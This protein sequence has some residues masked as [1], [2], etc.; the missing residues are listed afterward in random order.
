MGSSTHG[1]LGLMLLVI[2]MLM[3]QATAHTF[4]VGGKHGWVPKPKERY[5]KWAER[6]RFQVNDT[7][8]FKFHEKH[9]SVLVVD[10][11]SYLKCKTKH[12]IHKLGGH[13]HS[14]FKLD[15]SGPFYFISGRSKHCRRGQK[16]IVVVLALS[17]HKH[18]SHPPHH[19][20]HHAPSHVPSHAP[21]HA[22][23]H[24]PHHAHHHAPHHAPSH[25]PHHHAP[26]HHGPHHHAPHHAP[27]HHAPSHAPH[28]HAP[29]HAPHHHPPSHVPANAPS[30]V[31]RHAPASG[32]AHAH[33]WSPVH[34]PAP[35]PSSAASSRFG[36]SVSVA[37]GLGIWVVLVLSS[38]I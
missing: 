35:G 9:D 2:T 1:F 14:E 4:Y 24:A 20:P 18:P 5:N 37:M 8:H 34:A 29:S 10:K 13:G 31:P 36:G 12:P 7:L 16:L 19:A 11:E 38:F 25:A 26:H 32:P 33:S 22:P 30:S 6:T 15:R 28:H 17:H 27:H 21:H 3:L 23:S